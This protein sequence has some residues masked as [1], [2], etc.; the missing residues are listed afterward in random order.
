MRRRRHVT[1]DQRSTPLPGGVG[2]RAVNHAHVV[3]RHLAGFEFDIHGCRLIELIAV[4]F[5]VQHQ[6]LAI[7]LMVPVQLL[8]FVRPGDETHAPVHCRHRVDR[9]PHRTGRQ[10]PH[11]PVLAVLVPGYFAAVARRLAKHAS[12]P[13]DDIRA[14]HLLDHVQDRFM[15]RRLHE[16][17]QLRTLGRRNHVRIGEVLLCHVRISGQ[18]PVDTLPQPIQQRRRQAILREHIALFLILTQFV[19][20]QD[21]FHRLPDGKIVGGV[22]PV[23]H[24]TGVRRTLQ[25]H[26]SLVTCHRVILPRTSPGNAA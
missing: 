25:N 24:R 21:G 22:R 6:V 26:L 15:A 2:K 16:R 17:I 12:D 19:R 20:T 23:N 8:L 18:Q 5:Q 9:D 4:E 7:G 3:Q 13:Q 11:R 1:Q 14:Q 10:R